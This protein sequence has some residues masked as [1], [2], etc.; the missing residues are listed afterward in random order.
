MDAL[1]LDLSHPSVQFYLALVRL[2]VLTPLSLLLNIASLLICAILAQPS[3]PYLLHSHPTALT[4]NAHAIAVY[5]MAVWIAQIGY[6]VLLVTARKEETK[7]AMV[8][9]VGMAL[10]GANCVMALW[11][12]AFIMQWFLISTVLQ[13]IILLLLLFSNIALLIYHPPSSSRPLDTALIHAPIRFFFVLPLHILFPMSLFVALNL[14]YPQNIPVP[15]PPSTFPFSALVAHSGRTPALFV[16][17]GTNLF[18]LL[19][20]ALRRDIVYAV[21]ATWCAISLWTAEYPKPSG[22]YITSITFTAL[23]PLVL[24]LSMVYHHFY[25]APRQNRIALPGDERALG[26]SSTDTSVPP[27]YEARG[28]AQG[29]Q[30]GPREVEEENWG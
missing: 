29:M 10:V 24:I 21:A 23:Y 13:G 22:V 19:I 14:R 26:R 12:I 15:S 7:K 16:V 6:C 4:P 1:P 5:V 2:Q 8:S 27:G 18:G 25:Q 28:N 11:A 17:L 3:I 9:A 30:A 20:V